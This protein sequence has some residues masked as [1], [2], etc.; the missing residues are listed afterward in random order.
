MEKILRVMLTVSEHEEGVLQALEYGDLDLLT[1]REHQVLE[2]IAK[3]SRNK[4]IASKLFLS[5]ETIKHP[6]KNFTLRT[7]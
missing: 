1:K 6:I 7:E 4:D 5:E 3:E 2:E